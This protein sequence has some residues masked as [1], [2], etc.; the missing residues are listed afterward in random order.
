MTQLGRTRL[1]RTR[2]PGET[3]LLSRASSEARIFAE[4]CHWITWVSLK[5]NINKIIFMFRNLFH[6]LLWFMIPDLHISIP[7]YGRKSFQYCTISEL[8]LNLALTREG[9]STLAGKRTQRNA[10]PDP[11]HANTQH[12][13][14]FA[15]FYQNIYMTNR[16]R[17]HRIRNALQTG[18]AC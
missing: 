5:T 8:P 15:G 14:L 12:L 2:W 4:V 10:F 17:S 11:P 1:H 3:I 13:C 7:R 16:S 18:P 6:S 9:S